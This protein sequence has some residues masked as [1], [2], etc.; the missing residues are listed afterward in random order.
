MQIMRSRFHILVAV[1]V[2]LLSLL[3]SCEGLEGIEISIT[4]SY[5]GPRPE[6]EAFGVYSEDAPKLIYTEKKDQVS[7]YED[8]NGLW[9]RFITPGLLR[10]MEVG[11]IPDGA[12]PGDSFTATVSS[13]T[14][15]VEQ[16][17]ADFLMEVRN[18]YEGRIALA[19]GY[20][21]FILRL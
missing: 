8:E 6:P 12:V 19:S 17:S 20:S 13:R 14:A 3:S 18:V 5:N 21:W 2:C 4:P 9:V 10:I 16:Y 11:P 15:G 1:L 7:V